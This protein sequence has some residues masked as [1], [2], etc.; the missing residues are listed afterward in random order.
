M[1]L[2]LRTSKQCSGKS[3]ACPSQCRPPHCGVTPIKFEDQLCWATSQGEWHIMAVSNPG[4][5]AAAPSRGTPET[6]P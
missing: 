2:Q 6:A 3:Q 4:P 1:P 5:P